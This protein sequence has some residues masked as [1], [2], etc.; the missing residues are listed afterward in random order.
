MHRQNE[1]TRG[2]RVSRSKRQASRHIAAGGGRTPDESPYV[3]LPGRIFRKSS[4]WWWKVQL[5]GE[6]SP[7]NRALRAPGSRCGVLD[8]QAAGEIAFTMWQ[9][10]VRT[11]TEARIRAEQAQQTDQMKPSLEARASALADLVERAEARAE[12]QAAARIRLEA[13]LNALRKRPVQ[14]AICQCC[15]HPA[16]SGE[17]HRID[18]GQRLCPCCLYALRTDAQRQLRQSPATAH[19]LIGKT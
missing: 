13:E 6:S 19:R 4:R 15:G 1:N 3:K 7:R 5:P 10:A 16:A 9:E 14:Q 11:E 17:L 2:L 18:S 8:R 12:A